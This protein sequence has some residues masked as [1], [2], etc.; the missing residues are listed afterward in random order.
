MHYSLTYLE[1][2]HKELAAHLFGKSLT[3]RA[4]YLICGLSES[5]NET[6][7]L[8]R[9][10]IP[11]TSADVLD[12]SQTHMKIVARSFLS[13]IKKADAAKACF[14]FVHSHPSGMSKHSTRDDAE[15]EALFRTAYNRI[16]C[17]AIHASIVYSDVEKPIGRVWL[18]DG[19]TEP[20]Q[21]IRIVGDRFRFLH[22]PDTND[23]MSVDF[24]RYDRQVRAFGPEM[25]RL[26]SG[27]SVGVVGA[28]G[29][30][31]SVIEQLIRLGVGKVTISDGQHFEG[32]NVTRVYGS[33]CS[34]DGTAK[35]RIMERMASDVGTGT[36]IIPIA[37]PITF[38]S[39]MKQFRDCDVVFGC[40]DDQWGRSLLT[41]LNIYYYIP[42][43][44]MGVR[45][46]SE[47]GEL[48]SVQ[49]RVTILVP[50]TACLFCRRRITPEVIAAE[51]NEALDPVGA[52]QLRR[53]GYAPE[54]GSVAPAVITFT[55][56]IAASAVSEFLHR[57]TG[58]M[59]SERCSSEVIHLFDR[60]IV[61]ANHTPPRPGCFCADQKNWGR[62]DRP[63]FL[64]VAWRPE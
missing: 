34:D 9:E 3:E 61:R 62:G 58:F 47:H 16:H 22:A 4:A 39:A 44:D 19:R 11:V 57:V 21:L 2:Q 43:L 55:T 59:G 29:T 27:M 46:D 28:G 60:G 52:A 53:E 38:R 48:R 23:G 26:L 17:R 30:G 56:S 18:E 24:A 64:D 10:V 42:V 37:K 51:S 1:D 63:K 20:I 41:R 25:Q 32:S 35:T 45:I 8:V 14:V 7:L 5:T 36:R 31:S 13:A 33:R 12:S 40:T 54:L 15:E 6:R 49:G 50:G